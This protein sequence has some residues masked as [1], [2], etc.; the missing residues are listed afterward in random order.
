MAESGAQTM[1]ADSEELLD[2]AALPIATRLES[3][4]AQ[5]AFTMFAAFLALQLHELGHLI[6]YWLLG[7]AAWPAFHHAR[8]AAT[9]PAAHHLWT[10]PAGPLLSL[11]IGWA[12]LRVARQRRS[13]TWALAAFANASSRLFSC[14][15]A[16]VLLLSGGDGGYSDEGKIAAALFDAPALQAALLLAVLALA[17]GLAVAAAR[18]VDVRLPLVGRFA[19][20]Y[21]VCYSVGIF[22]F[23]V[24]ALLGWL[25]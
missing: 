21:V 20:L 12:C 11:G 22:A 9:V 24:D 8:T 16:L 25:D 23:Q 17:L 2:V 18:R 1:P 14:V 13:M 6:S 19:A 10:R 4:L 3:P 7:D 15:G 5:I